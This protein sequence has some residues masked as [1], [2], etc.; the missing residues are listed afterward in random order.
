MLKRYLFL[1]IVVCFAISTVS[2]EEI[3]DETISYDSCLMADSVSEYNSNMILNDKE[4][5]ESVDNGT[6]TDL[7]K[8]INNADVGSTIT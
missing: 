3:S 8:K 2:A 6:F 1:I 4:I 7:Q 5:Q